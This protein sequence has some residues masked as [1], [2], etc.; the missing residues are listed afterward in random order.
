MRARLV[1]LAW[2]LRGSFV[3]PCAGKVC[4]VRGHARGHALCASFVPPCA[5]KEVVAHR[6]AKEAE[7]SCGLMWEMAI[8]VVLRILKR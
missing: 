1:K 4:R 8:I 3:L 7:A 5:G 2:V 6:E